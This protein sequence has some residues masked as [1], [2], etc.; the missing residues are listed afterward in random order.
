MKCVQGW[1][2]YKSTFGA[3]A[4]PLLGLHHWWQG[5]GPVAP[6]QPSP[7]SCNCLLLIWTW[8][9]CHLLEAS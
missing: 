9:L 1:L 2:A 3:Q 5:E 8:N 7:R 4:I 6:V